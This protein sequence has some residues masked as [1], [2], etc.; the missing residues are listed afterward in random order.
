MGKGAGQVGPGYLGL[1]IYG[2][3]PKLGGGGGGTLLGGF[4][5]KD[6]R[7]LGSV[8]GSPYFGILPYEDDFGRLLQIS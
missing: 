5:K 1:S 4:Y 6:H 3:F 7:V 8:E 2:G